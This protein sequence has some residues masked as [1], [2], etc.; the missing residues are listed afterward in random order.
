[1]L[2][3]AAVCLTSESG[4]LGILLI[5]DE[6]GKLLEYAASNPSSSDVYQLQRLAEHCARSAVPILLLGVLHQDFIGY[7][8]ELP[9]SQR[10]EWEKIRG[11][12]EDIIFEQSADDLLRLIADAMSSHRKE[13]L[14]VTPL[15]KSLCQSAWS[16]KIVPPGLEQVSGLPL[17]TACFPMHPCVTLLLG[18]VF[19][20]F[21][22][23]ERSAF[24]FLTSSEPNALADFA[25]NHGSDQLYSLND[26]YEYLVGIFGD[27]LLTGRDGKRWAEAFNVESQHLDLKLGELSVLRTVAILGIVGRWNGVS[28]TQKV[29]KLALAP[30]MDATDVDVHLRSLL[31]KSAIIYR[32]YNDTYSLWEGSDIDVEARIADARS[33]IAAD[34][35]AVELL[36]THFTPRPLVARRHSFE[37]GT[38]RYFDIMFATPSKLPELNT[39]LEQQDDGS[40]ADGRIVVV[41]PDARGGIL[42]PAAAAAQAVMARQDTILCVPGNASEVETLARELAA[43]EWVSNATTDLQNDATPSWAAA[44]LSRRANSG[45]S[46]SSSS[47]RGRSPPRQARS[48]VP[49]VAYS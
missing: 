23:N 18:P 44:L 2:D 46:P 4:A 35:S 26:L 47:S 40:H 13:G 5:F 30:A 17:L 45:A 7:A 10:Q 15:F 14:R 3:R 19:K 21:G 6:L 48:L 32:R 37:R 38:L 11:R 9:D 36:R 42:N 34:A 31:N 43:V 27:S 29:L 25:A 49:M 12:F 39:A 20:R 16:A 33:R 28:A 1:M 8:S 24:S 41:I 22:Q